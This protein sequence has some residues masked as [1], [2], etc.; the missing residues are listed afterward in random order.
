MKQLKPSGMRS[1]RDVRLEKERLRY[2]ALRTELELSKDL[3]KIKK[4]FT[5]PD[6]LAQTGHSITNYLVKAIRSWFF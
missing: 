4:S 2:L 5:F 1:L 6:I 3:R